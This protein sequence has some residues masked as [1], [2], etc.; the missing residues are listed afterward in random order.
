M[1]I[2]ELLEKNGET[3]KQVPL[4]IISYIEV[5]AVDHHYS[6]QDARAVQ[7][8]GGV[9]YV[10]QLYGG[11]NGHSDWVRYFDNLKNLMEHFINDG[12]HAWCIQLKNDCPDDVHDVFIGL[13]LDDELYNEKHRSKLK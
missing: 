1:L 6:F 13:E 9:H 8:S 7:G 5:T 12:Y 3:G 11:N 10:V 2:D 4:E